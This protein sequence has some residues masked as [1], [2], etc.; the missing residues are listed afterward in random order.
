MQRH[1]HIYDFDIWTLSIRHIR[2]NKKQ[3]NKNQNQKKIL[4]LKMRFMETIVVIIDYSMIIL[5]FFL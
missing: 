5:F 4:T 1:T 3:K 2:K